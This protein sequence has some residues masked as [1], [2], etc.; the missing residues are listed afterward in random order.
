MDDPRLARRAA[1]GTELSAELDE[2]GVG[3]L[4]S[5]PGRRGERIDRDKPVHVVQGTPHPGVLLTCPG[6]VFGRS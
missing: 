6:H 3:L 4:K 1:P 5:E 2:Y